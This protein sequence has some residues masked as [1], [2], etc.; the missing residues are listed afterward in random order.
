MLSTLALFNLSY[1]Q[2]F[3]SM[4]VWRCV[5]QSHFFSCRLRILHESTLYVN[6]IYSFLSS[7]APHIPL[8]TALKCMC[9]GLK[10]KDW[11][12]WKKQIKQN[13]PKPWSLPSSAASTVQS[14]LPA[15]WV[16]W[17]LPPFMSACWLVQAMQVWCRHPY[18]W[19]LMKA[20]SQSCLEHSIKQQ[21]AW[22]LWFYRLCPPSS[23]SFF[24]TE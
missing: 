23:V 14:S 20:T 24:H 4:W 12:F 2:L 1:L 22:S 18:Y 8:N 5:S 7:D 3:K 11:G 15:D 21:T 13:E 19:L 9:L 17:R 16:L 10:S 6:H